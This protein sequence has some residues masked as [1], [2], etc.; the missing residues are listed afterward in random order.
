M[1]LYSIPL[2]RAHSYHRKLSLLFLSSQLYSYKAP[3]CLRMAL[4]SRDK[5]PGSH[6]PSCWFVQDSST[7][8]CSSEMKEKGCG[9]QTPHFLCQYHPCRALLS[10]SVLC[11]RFLILPVLWVSQLPTPSPPPPPCCLLPQTSDEP[12]GSC[13]I[14]FSQ[15][16]RLSGGRPKPPVDTHSHVC[17]PATPSLPVLMTSLLTAPWLP[18]TFASESPGPSLPFHLTHCPQK[19]RL[20]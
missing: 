19:P 6:S 18:S 10:S 20:T 16:V 1:R 9:S 11:L 2:S 12:H 17:C 15:P 7:L 13:F 8:F 14:P 4:S 5:G 3:F